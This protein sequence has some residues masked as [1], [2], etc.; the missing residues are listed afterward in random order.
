[1]T[2]AL[3]F[4]YKEKGERK[5]DKLRNFFKEKMIIFLKKILGIQSPSKNKTHIYYE[6]KD[7]PCNKNQIFYKSEKW[8][9]IQRRDDYYDRIERR[10]NE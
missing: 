4:I 10:K 8:K 2:K 6:E 9:R 3:F 5:M 7:T 1:M